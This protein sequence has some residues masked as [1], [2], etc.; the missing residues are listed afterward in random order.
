[1]AAITVSFR[2]TDIKLPEIYPKAGFWSA[3][4]APNPKDVA[5][6]PILDSLLILAST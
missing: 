1:V 6:P 5:Q 4:N 3:G 2:I